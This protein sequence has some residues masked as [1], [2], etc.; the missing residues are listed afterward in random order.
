MNF[1]NILYKMIVGFNIKYIPDISIDVSNN[2]M[3]D[4]KA[5]CFINIEESREKKC[6]T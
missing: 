5:D 3:I 1:I 6:R 4:L 2:L